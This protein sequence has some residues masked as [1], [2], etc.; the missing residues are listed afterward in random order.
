MV[1]FRYI[2]LNTLYIVGDGNDDDNDNDYY[3]YY[4]KVIS[5]IKKAI[6]LDVA[7][8]WISEKSEK[9]RLSNDGST[10]LSEEICGG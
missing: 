7:D 2:I 8:L 3:Y 5:K 1:C 10:V 6:A 4:Y 9:S